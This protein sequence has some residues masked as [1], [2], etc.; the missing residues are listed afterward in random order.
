MNHLHQDLLPL[1]SVQDTVE[2]DTDSIA[3][4]EDDAALMLDDFDND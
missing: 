1:M 2:Q 4:V 3:E